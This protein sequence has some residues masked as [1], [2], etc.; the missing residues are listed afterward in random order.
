MELHINRINRQPSID[1]QIQQRI[2]NTI[3]DLINKL[4]SIE[5]NLISD[6]EKQNMINNIKEHQKIILEIFKKG[7]SETSYEITRSMKN[8]KSQNTH[9]DPEI[10]IL[11]SHIQIALTHME[12]EYKNDREFIIYIT[13]R[14]M[15]LN[16]ALENNYLKENAI[17][18]MIDHNNQKEDER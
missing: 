17:L 8:K 12:E 18:K 14:R 1:Y 5:F 2:I 16:T 4:N 11:K 15:F 6:K 10:D 13:D 7:F 9:K 3:Q